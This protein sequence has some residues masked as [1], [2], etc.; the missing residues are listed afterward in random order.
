MDVEI[1]FEVIGIGVG[2]IVM[3]IIFIPYME[4]KGFFA[5]LLFTSLSFLL[6]GV[7]IP[8]I[9]RGYYIKKYHLQEAV[10]VEIP[11]KEMEVSKEEEMPKEEE[12]PKEEV[13]ISKEEKEEK[14]EASD[15]SGEKSQ[16][17]KETPKENRKN[18]KRRRMSKMENIKAFVRAR[19]IKPQKKSV[20]FTYLLAIILLMMIVMVIYGNV[21]GHF[22][23]IGVILTIAAG[24]LSVMGS[25]VLKGKTKEY[26]FSFTPCNM[27]PLEPP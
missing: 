15:E 10:V 23:K 4:L 17:E 9:L 13:K 24:I 25:A 11:K 6:I 5:W 27:E 22:N 26:Y 19:P 12:I 21:N 16:K 18:H 1:F 8:S 14:K 3:A 7:S 20:V 2:V